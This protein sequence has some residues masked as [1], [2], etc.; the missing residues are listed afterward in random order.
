M[1]PIFIAKNQM[2]AV[3]YIRQRNAALLLLLLRAK[4][5]GAP[6]KLAIQLR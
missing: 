1:D 2:N 4:R 5:S 3:I 6:A